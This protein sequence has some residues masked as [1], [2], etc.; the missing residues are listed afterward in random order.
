VAQQERAVT[1]HV[2]DEV[3]AVGVRLVAA[4]RADDGDRK[5]SRPADVMGDPSR[6]DPAGTFVELA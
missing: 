4:L 5:R 1:H 2:A 6:D 3:V